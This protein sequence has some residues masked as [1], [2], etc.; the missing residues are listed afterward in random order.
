M[1]Y[2]TNQFSSAMQHMLLISNIKL[3]ATLKCYT[4]TKDKWQRRRQKPVRFCQN[5]Y[6][7]GYYVELEGRMVKIHSFFEHSKIYLAILIIKLSYLY[8][9]VRFTEILSLFKTKA[10]FSKTCKSGCLTDVQGVKGYLCTFF[11]PQ[12]IKKISN[13]EGIGK[14]NFCFNSDSQLQIKTQRYLTC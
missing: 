3:A 13:H 9:H 12:F 8:P 1:I 11:M 4:G 5:A 14:K 6:S 2:V 7:D 10:L